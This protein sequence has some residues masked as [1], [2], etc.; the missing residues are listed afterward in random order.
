LDGLLLRIN[1]DFL[2]SLEK[3]GLMISDMR[4][5]FTPR[6]MI[7]TGYRTVFKRIRSFSEFNS[8]YGKVINDRR[9]QCYAGPFPVIENIRLINK[10]LSFK[11]IYN[12]YNITESRKLVKEISY[13]SLRKDF[14][15]TEV[16]RYLNLMNSRFDQYTKDTSTAIDVRLNSYMDPCYVDA[17]YVSPNSN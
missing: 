2:L 9:Y 8:I 5:R 3:N 6:D 14:Y 4:I 16:Q 7:V 13:D 1:Y 12:W 10:N 17:G 11:N 15:E